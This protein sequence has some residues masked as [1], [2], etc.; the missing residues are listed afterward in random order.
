MSG[1]LAVKASLRTLHI[2]KDNDRALVHG[3]ACLV[4]LT[5]GEEPDGAATIVH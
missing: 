4:W 5:L 3:G 1:K 2:V